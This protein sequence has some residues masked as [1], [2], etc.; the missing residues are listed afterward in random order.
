MGNP[1]PERVLESQWLPAPLDHA[2][3]ACATLCLSLSGLPLIFECL[4]LEWLAR[5]LRVQVLLRQQHSNLSARPFEMKYVFTIFKTVIVNPNTVYATVR[6]VSTSAASIA[7][8]ESASG[9][10]L[11][12]LVPTDG[13]TRPEEITRTMT[14]HV[15]YQ[16]CFAVQCYQAV[17]QYLQGNV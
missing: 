17:R 1:S 13:S 3:E 15:T 10:A 14:R 12:C 8:A 9:K 11:V 16:R 2:I 4:Y 7:P 6:N 5:I